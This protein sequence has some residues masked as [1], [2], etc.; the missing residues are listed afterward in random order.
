M[1]AMPG[2]EA[3]AA[4][5][6]LPLGD[7]SSAQL[8]DIE[9]RAVAARQTGRRAAYRAVSASY[10]G[11]LRIPLVRGRA[12]TEDDREDSPLVVVINEA[13]ARTF[14]PNQDPMGQRIRWATGIRPFDEP[15][16]TVVGVAADVKSNGLDKPEPP[17]IYAPYTQRMFTWLRW[18]SFVV[19]THG[20]PQSY[21]RAIREE[22]TKIDPMQPIYQMAS[23]DTV[24]SQ[25]VAA[26]RFHTGLV[27]VFAALALGLCAVGVYGTIRYWVAERTREIGVRMALGA[28]RRGIML[29]VVARAERL[30]GDRRRA[31]HRPVARD[32]P[33]AVDA[34]VRRGVVRHRH[35][36]DGGAH[37]ARHRGGGR[38]HPR[39]PRVDARSAVGDSR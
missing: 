36:R 18:N 24:I 7:P 21:A 4:V 15:W 20:E 3:V 5:S 13:S 26:R 32:Q 25:S 10:F 29:M 31:R 35:H 23:L 33:R 22:L 2:V 34:A 6:Q 19:R 28:T 30:H 39:A 17:A 14:W 37:R 12:L 38:V 1:A 27:D 9:G 11:T 8:F 16:H